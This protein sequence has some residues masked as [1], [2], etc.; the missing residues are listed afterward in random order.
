MSIART[1]S[2]LVVGIGLGWII[3]SVSGTRTDSPAPG[4][5]P[6]EPS[7]APVAEEPRAANQDHRSAGEQRPHAHHHDEVPFADCPIAGLARSDPDP[8][9]DRAARGYAANEFAIAYSCADIVAEQVP[10]SVD[11]HHIRAAAASALGR[12]DAA[13]LAFARALALDPEDPQTLAAAAEF[14]I[15]VLPNRHRETT[16]IGL[17]YA[18]R[19]RSQTRVRSRAGKLER[20]RLALLEAQAY[21]DLGAGDEALE[22]IGEALNLTPNLL[23]A[24][25][26]RGLALFNLCRFEAA[27]DAFLRVLDS[28][29]DD[30]YA[31]H[32]LGLIYERLGAEERAESHLQRAQELAPDEFWPPVLLSEQEFRAELDRAISELPAE[33]RAMVAQVTVQVIDVP[34]DADLMAVHPPF[35]PTILGLFRGL[36]LGVDMAQLADG[37]PVPARAIILY[38]KNLARTVRTRAELDEQIRRT[39]LHEIGHLSGLN[40][41]DLRRRGLD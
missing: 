13:Q 30:P 27:R 19:G 23:E 38:R 24:K 1:L 34:E 26:E 29:P 17:E 20:A 9:L 28:A 6:A 3:A 31:H 32:H 16:L 7:P 5:S 37:E 18:R 41:G 33:Y 39:L 22:R 10:G 36:P 40:E 25:H 8:L 14:Y 2:L 11:A 15:N 35:S 12:Y 4:Q 21:N